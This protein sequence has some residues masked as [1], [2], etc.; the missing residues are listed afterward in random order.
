MVTNFDNFYAV[1]EQAKVS[2]SSRSIVLSINESKPS[3]V[4]FENCGWGWVGRLYGLE[5]LR[6]YILYFQTLL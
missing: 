6:K 5:I 3:Q 1:T 4:Y 2:L